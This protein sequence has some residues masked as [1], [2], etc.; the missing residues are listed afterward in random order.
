MKAKTLMIQGTGSHVGKSIITAALCRIFTQDGY[1]VAPFKSQ[2]MSLNS[3]ITEDGGEMGR[4]QVVQ[5]EACGIKPSVKM[6][7]I[8][9]KP[10]MDVS[11]QVIVMGRPVDNMTVEE[12]IQ[13]KP[14]A[15]K[16]A[17]TA[18]HSLKGSY[19]IVLIEG[20]GSPAEIN[21]RSH[22]I[23]NMGIAEIADAPV[24]IVGD[25]DKGGVFAWFVGTM[26]L[27]D[28]KEQERVKGFI[29]NKFRGR[30]ELLEPGLRYL[31]ERTERP[32]IG[33]IPYFSD[34]CVM[35]EDAVSD[36][37]IRCH[38]K[39][40]P[41]K[42][43]GI[44]IDVIHLP[45]ISNFT[46]FDPLEMEPEVHLRYVMRPQDIH[47]P[48]ILIIP[49]SKNTISD[50]NYLGAS[51][52]GRKIIESANN[53]TMIIGICGGYQMLGRRIYDRKGVE[54]KSTETGGLGLL[55]MVTEFREEK[56]THQV[57][58]IH[59][60]TGLEISGYEIHMG[61]SKILGNPFPVFKIVRRGYDPVEVPDGLK[62]EKGNVWG[63]YLHG[64]FEDDIFRRWFLN[65]LRIKKGLHPIDRVIPFD[66]ERE[67]DKLA[68][69]VRQ[70]LDME[71]L[72]RIL[73]I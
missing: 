25:I 57:K 49:G 69:L 10:T 28:Q 40:A 65:S 19:E 59:T 43:D 47:S 16:I 63:T 72:Y 2:N 9:L 8:L 24:L 30:R 62:N 27:L 14:E 51:G 54:S 53:G 38:G 32:A 66:K 67:Y 22:D 41:D 18:L 68:D 39:G 6:N 35:E 46:D 26:E 37:K 3:F 48:D 36:S 13:F 42:K 33:V 23:V 4:A 60:D 70:N 73:G 55:E 45:H 20:A 5:A 31:E 15:M 17:T 1:R 61:E 44:T 71:A 50:V 34:I 58:A 29:I 56:M 12:Y 21:L 64:I 11:A 52:M 7:P